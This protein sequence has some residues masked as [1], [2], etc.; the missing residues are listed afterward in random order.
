MIGF[1][2]FSLVVIWVVVSA[3][4]SFL[5]SRRDEQMFALRTHRDLALAQEEKK[6]LAI[7]ARA[8]GAAA[9][10]DKR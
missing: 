8:M 10:S 1:V 2:I 5:R 4:R 7:L 9:V 3:L 6:R